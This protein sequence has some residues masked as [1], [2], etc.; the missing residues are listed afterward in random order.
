MFHS[1]LRGV[2]NVFCLERFVCVGDTLSGTP[3]DVWRL[4]FLMSDDDIMCHFTV[5]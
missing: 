3:L 2:G 4:N 5:M 1:F